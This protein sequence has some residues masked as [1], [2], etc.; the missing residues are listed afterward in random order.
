MRKTGSIREHYDL[1]L[2]VADNLAIIR[3]K[4]EILKNL[5]TDDL[6]NNNYV[7]LVPNADDLWEQVPVYKAWDNTW[8]ITKAP[9][10]PANYYGES[11]D[12]L[13]EPEMGCA[14]GDDS[15]VL[16]SKIN[17]FRTKK[18]ADTTDP[19]NARYCDSYAQWNPANRLILMQQRTARFDAQLAAYNSE[20][21]AKL[22]AHKDRIAKLNQSLTNATTS[23]NEIAPKF[24]EELR[25]INA[26]I[27]KMDAS[28]S[29]NTTRL[30]TLKETAIATRIKEINDAHAA[31]M[32]SINNSIN[33]VSAE[34]AKLIEEFN[35]LQAKVTLDS[36]YAKALE[37]EYNRL[38]SA[39]NAA[40]AASAP[41]ATSTTPA[42]PMGPQ[43]TPKLPTP[44]VATKPQGAT[45]NKSLQPEEPLSA[46]LK[47]CV[48][49]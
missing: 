7:G 20:L 8:Y 21:D 14:I 30:A 13:C 28:I 48:I 12:V 26:D 37:S 44:P 43:T 18:C 38:L 9:P 32:T 35:I 11:C 46:K 25:L 34:L 33:G 5:L 10:C 49:L 3:N 31:A 4:Y 17:T 22:A 29:E 24:A 23:F 36:N 42:V 2:S 6:F 19:G 27:A 39:K 47:K 41:R 1:A 40:V 15:T 45:I 16:K